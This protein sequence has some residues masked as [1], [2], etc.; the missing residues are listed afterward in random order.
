MGFGV[1]C[2]GLAV[3]R[4][5]ARRARLR[6]RPAPPPQPRA[7]QVPAVLRRG[8]GL[9][10]DAHRRPR[11]ARR[12]R[13]RGCRAPRCSSCSA[14]LAISRAAAAQ[15]LRQR[16]PHLLRACSRA[17]RRRA[18][19]TCV[20]VCAAALLAFVGAVGALSIDAR[21]RRRVP[22]RARATRR[23]TSASDAPRSMLRPDGAARG[24]HRRSSGSCP[25]LGARARRAGARARSA[26][27]GAPPRRR[28]RRAARAGVWARRGARASRSPV[29]ASSRWRRRA[30]ARAQRDLGLR[31]HRRNAR[32]Q[33]TGSS[34][35][36]QFARSF[37]A[38][39]P[40]LR[41]ERLPDG[42]VP[43]S[44]RRTSR[45]HHVDAVE[46]RMFEVL[47]QGEDFVTQ[48]SAR[49]PEQPR[50][51]FAAGLLALV[52]DRG[53]RRSGSVPMS[54]L[55]SPTCSRSLVMPIVLVGVDQPRQGAVVGAH[56]ASR[57]P[58]RVRRACA[59]LRKR[60]ST[61]RSR[62]R[63]SASAPLVV[64]VTALGARRASSRCSAP[65]PLVVVPVRLRRVRLRLGARARRADAR[66]ARHRQLVRGHGR[67]REAT[68]ATLLEPALFLVA[69]ALCLLTGQRTLRD[70]A[71]APRST[72]G[73]ALVVWVAAHRRAVHRR[74]GR[75]GAHAG[76][77]SDHPPR[78]HDGARGDDPRPQRP[79]ARGAPARRGDQA[80]RRALASS[81][82]CSTRSPAPSRA[83]VAVAV[84]LGAR[85]SASRS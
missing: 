25:A 74:A 33:Y 19:A 60:R 9:P 34:F 46:R 24:R 58:A 76:R 12:P 66:R 11:A 32:M 15:R 72:A 84:H 8:R 7:L 71:G 4:P 45:T 41:R 61:A 65:A 29:A 13:A 18:T 22:R 17:R 68:F 42:A 49:I 57:L 38:L 44:T 51:A 35:S 63:S 21:V 1:G 50:F 39:L 5:G 81:R 16:V 10:R 70:G 31:L 85:A 23:S 30:R 20:L 27:P 69:G 67:G 37:D 82:R 75:G 52:V 73:A 14:A 64:L 36:A 78:A 59:S 26:A 3:G 56:G 80:V 83:L 48:T 2:L 55:A 47:G 28:P 6:R 43:R 62:R 77:R 79:R 54:A 53:C 40:A